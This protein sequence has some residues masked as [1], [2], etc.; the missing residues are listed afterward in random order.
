MRERGRLAGGWGTHDDR[1]MRWQAILALAA[2]G[3]FVAGL[4]FVR[5]PGDHGPLVQS[6][7]SMGLGSSPP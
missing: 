7:W 1:R 5:L 4:S 3:V 2:F 6:L